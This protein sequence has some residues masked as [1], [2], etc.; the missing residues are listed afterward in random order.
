MVFSIENLVTY[1]QP[2]NE[3]NYC[4]KEIRWFFHNEIDQRMELWKN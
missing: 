2:G 1:Q 3:D 4:S